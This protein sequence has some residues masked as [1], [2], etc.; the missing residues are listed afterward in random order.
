MK[1][2][3]ESH[4]KTQRSQASLVIMSRAVDGERQLSQ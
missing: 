4:D 2:S 1:S 3:D